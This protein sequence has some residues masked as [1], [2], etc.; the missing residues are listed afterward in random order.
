VLVA[1]EVEALD[2]LDNSGVIC[3]VSHIRSRSAFLLDLLRC[4]L[5]V[6]GSVFVFVVRCI[7]AACVGTFVG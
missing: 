4:P 7:A 1:H 2:L 6:L 3:D 5:L